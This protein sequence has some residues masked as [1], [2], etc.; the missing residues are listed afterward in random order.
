[1]AYVGL[2][3][4]IIARYHDGIYSGGSRLGK[5]IRMEITPE[6]EDVSDYEDI[7]NTDDSEIFAYADVSLGTDALQGNA[8]K[9]VFGHEQLGDETICK[10]TDQAVYVGVGFRVREKILGT[11]RYVAMWLC[12]VKFKEEGE[13]HKTREN[14]IDYVTPE[15]KG[16]AYPDENGQWKRKK[17]FYTQK[18]ADSW[19]NQMAGIVE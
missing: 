15:I 8:E 17:I 1:M 19:L 6:Y 16:K 14:S 2:A 3:E 13:K 18:E 4:P 7:N 10:D 12:K 5:A 9:V 11:E